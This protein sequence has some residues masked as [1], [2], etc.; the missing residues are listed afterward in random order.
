[1]KVNKAYKF[2]IYPTEKQK[3]LMAKHFGATRFC[4]NYFLNK[5]K[6]SYLE[7]KKTLTYYDNAK[8]LTTLKKE[9]DFKWLKEIN[10]QSLQASLKDLD[11]A[12]GRFF[13]KQAM[14]P[15]FKSKHM[16]NNSFRCPQQVFLKDKKLII[17]KFRKG[18]KI[19]IHCE[20]NGKIL[21]ATISKTHTNKYFASIT[22]EVE[23]KPFSKVNKDIGI[24][25][26]I[27]NLAICS[28]GKVFTNPKT[29]KKYAKKLAHEQRRLFKKKK[30]SSNRI[31]QKKQ[32]ARIHEK[33]KN[34]RIDNIHKITHSIISENQT[35]AI[36]DLN[37]TGMIKNHHLAKAIADVSWSEITRQL[38]YKAKWNER[39]LIKIDRWFPSSKTCNV[40]NYIKQNLTLKDR[41]W[42]CPQC[43]SILDRDINAAKNILKQGLK[44]LSGCGTQSEL[45]QKPCEASGCKQSL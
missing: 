27:K 28:D 9:D 22:C 38:A 3:I 10:S 19:K 1:M 14:F 12:Y 43:N 25:L 34:V 39:N 36:E 35:I 17:P 40:C 11:T 32:V 2:R 6:E 16:S 4:W 8:F 24:D 18:I 20:V 31:K 5:R 30:G 26:G 45:K 37:V 44:I 23:H 15:K 33:I 29:Q 42:V 41:E 13:K 21:F 7:N